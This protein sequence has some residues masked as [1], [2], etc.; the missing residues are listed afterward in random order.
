[1][2]LL[3]IRHR[4][5]TTAREITKLATYFEPQNYLFY[6]GNHGSQGVISDGCH[7]VADSAFLS[8]TLRSL[9]SAAL[10]V[11]ADTWYHSF[12]EQMYE[13]TEDEV[14]QKALDLEENLQSSLCKTNRGL[15]AF[16]SNHL[17][18]L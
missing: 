11:I 1:M 12:G 10:A 3:R 15:S 16:L 14:L 6:L 9:C 17:E 18:Q 8:C 4:A 2:A 5:K 13:Y 7:T